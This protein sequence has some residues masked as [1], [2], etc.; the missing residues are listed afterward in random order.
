M[1]TRGF[2]SVSEWAREVAKWRGRQTVQKILGQTIAG[3]YR[4]IIDRGDLV[5]DVGANHGV[6]VDQI[7]RRGGRVVAIEPQAT[8]ALE[9]KRRFPEATVLQAAAG[10][11][12]STAALV[13]ATGNDLLATLSA[14]WQAASGWSAE[15]WDA[16]EQV[17]VITLNSVIEEY[18][19]PKLVKIDTEGYEGEVLAGL[20][21]PIDHIVFEVH[22]DLPDVA[23]RCLD[24]LAEF[25]GY[26][27][28]IM[29][30]DRWAFSGPLTSAEV[31]ERLPSWGDVYA[32]RTRL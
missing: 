1:R 32:K 12:P 17:E 20:S 29:E 30:E 16:R 31:L 2:D 10:S 21:T 18:G 13:S 9:L 11:A 8:L 5:I 24:S 7:L 3:F 14:Q 28:R 23:E 26:E 22:A 4:R 27:L 25:G 6:H 15:M 19:Q